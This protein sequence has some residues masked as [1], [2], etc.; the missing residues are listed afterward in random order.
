[1]QRRRHDADRQQQGQLAIRIVTDAPVTKR[2]KPG[3]EVAPQVAPEIDEQR[4]ERAHVE[5]HVELRRC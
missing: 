5:H 2:R 3:H 4:R 1:M